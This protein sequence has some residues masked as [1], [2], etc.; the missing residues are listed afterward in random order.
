MT[1]P[2]WTDAATAVASIATAV[3]TFGLIVTAI[4]QIGGLREENRKWETV[5]A[6]I[7][8][9]QDPI[10]FERAKQV[11]TRSKGTDYALANMMP[12]MQELR[13]ILNYRDSLAVGVAQ[14]VYIEHIVRDTLQLVIEKAVDNFCRQEFRTELNMDGF[15]HLIDLRERWKPDAAVQYRAD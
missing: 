4:K 8:Y 6:C 14:G 2:S 15:S 5:K 11:R 9:T 7:A 1:D 13:A 12:V 3:A 10:L